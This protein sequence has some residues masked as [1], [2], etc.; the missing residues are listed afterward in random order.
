[1]SREND[2]NKNSDLSLKKQMKQFNEELNSYKKEVDEKIDSFNFLFKT[3]FLDYELNKPAEILYY[4]QNLG[5]ELLVFVN[6][7][8]KM[9]NLEWWLDYGNLIGA[10]RHGN[11]VPWDD[12]VDIGMMRKDFLEFDRIFAKEVK[13][14]GIDD[15]VEVG[16]RPRNIGNG[17]TISTFIQI[18]VRHQI[19]TSGKRRPILA[20]VDIFPYDYI[21]EY[22][23]KT[24]NDQ[25][26]DAKKRFFNHKKNHFNLQFSFDQYYEDLNLSLN[27]TD[28]IIAGVETACGP[29]EIYDL[30]IFDTDKIFPLSEIQYGDVI[31]PCPRDVDYYLKKIYKNYLDIPKSL[32]RHNRQDWYRYNPNNDEVFGKCLNKLKKAN[33]NFK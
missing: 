8:C 10:V 12:D 7:I 19:A 1:M 9:Y 29:D 28:S 26:L 31:F 33:S 24:I 17:K 20:S 16:Y 2:S 27:P 22:D 23:V 5:T 6:N 25:F 4:I 11:Y 30:A 32:H 3:R 13:N 21:K 14:Y 15:I 18:Y